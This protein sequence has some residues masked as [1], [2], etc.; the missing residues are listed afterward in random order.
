MVMCIKWG[1]QVVHHVFLL[2]NTNVFCLNLQ[3]CSSY[4]QNKTT[5]SHNP[6]FNNLNKCKLAIVKVK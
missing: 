2:V 1:L 4:P 6:K 3:G 5:R